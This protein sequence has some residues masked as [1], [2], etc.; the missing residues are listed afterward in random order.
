[1]LGDA[2]FL[3][4]SVAKAAG[5]PVIHAAGHDIPTLLK[6]SLQLM[7]LDKF[8]ESTVTSKLR[9]CVVILSDDFQ[10]PHLVGAHIPPRFHFQNQLNRPIEN[11]CSHMQ[12]S[13]I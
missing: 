10:L 6:A 4:T 7:P 2:N 12:W 3:S 11:S 1:M 9:T 8:V 5:T 13:A